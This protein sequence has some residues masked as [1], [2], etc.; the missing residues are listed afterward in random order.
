M[1]WMKKLEEETTGVT[2]T[3]ALDLD[4]VA[5]WEYTSGDAIPSKIHITFKSGKTMGFENKI[6]A[7]LFDAL[8]KGWL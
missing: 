4:Q 3:I 1:M 5:H 2:Y 7:D 6:A 8:E